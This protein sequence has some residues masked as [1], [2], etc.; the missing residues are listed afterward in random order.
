MNDWLAI[1]KSYGKMEYLITFKLHLLIQYVSFLLQ[2]Q[3]VTT[4]FVA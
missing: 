4:N 3:Q 2:L 1:L